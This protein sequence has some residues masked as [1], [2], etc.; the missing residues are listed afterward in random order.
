MKSERISPFWVNGYQPFSA[1]PLGKP[2]MALQVYLQALL[3]TRHKTSPQQIQEC[4]GV[5]SFL[6]QE[7]KKKGFKNTDAQASYDQTS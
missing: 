2:R 5:L 7:K 1:T 4:G 6:L 3:G